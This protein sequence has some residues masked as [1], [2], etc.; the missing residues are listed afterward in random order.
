M[1]FVVWVV[2]FGMV[3]FDFYVVGSVGFVWVGV[4]FD[5]VWVVGICWVVVVVY[6]NYVFVG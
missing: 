2:I 5:E 3:M 1:V 4:W 6:E